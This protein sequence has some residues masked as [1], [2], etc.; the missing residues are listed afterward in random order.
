VLFQ[1]RSGVRS[2]RTRSGGVGL[3]TCAAIYVG[4]Q[5]E[6]RWL[7]LEYSR[8][9]DAGY[10]CPFTLDE[11]FLRMCRWVTAIYLNTGP[12]ESSPTGLYEEL[13]KAVNDQQNAADLL[14]NVHVR[15]TEKAYRRIVL[16]DESET[17]YYGHIF[18]AL[19]PFEMLAFH[20]LI[21]ARAPKSIE[22]VHPAIAHLKRR[23]C[24]R[25]KL[26]G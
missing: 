17:N 20:R 9:F 12:T 23:V 11:D 14:G 15:R 4:A 16:E 3:A 26:R 21:A 2:L 6:A 24:L 10:Q 19:F 5:K 7:G 8:H 18:P 25:R 13:P 1:E 22:L